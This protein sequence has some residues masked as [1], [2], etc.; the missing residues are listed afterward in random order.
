[1]EKK[2]SRK[3]L[4]C[5]ILFALPFVGVGLVATYLAGS[6]LFDW[7]RMKSWEEVPAQIVSVERESHRS[8]NSTSYRVTARYL[9][10]VDGVEHQGTRVALY[11]GAVGFEGY[12]KDVYAELSEH[13]RSKQPFRCF[14]NPVLVSES[15]LYRELHWGLL[16]FFGIFVVAFGGFGLGL[17]GAGIRG[18]AVARKEEELR[19]LAPDQPWLHKEEWRSRRIPS[20]MK[21]TVMLSGVMAIFWN[22]VSVPLAF[23]VPR[24][25]EKGNHAALIVLIF[26]IV[27][28]G[29]AIWAGQSFL[30]YRKFGR[31]VLSLRS[32]PGVVGGPLE[33]QVETGVTMPPETSFHLTLSSV[34]RVR[35]ASGRNRSTRE[36]VLW[37]RVQELDGEVHF[38]REG[39]VVPISFSIPFSCRPTDESDPDDR[40][41][42]RL[43]IDAA[44]PGIDYHAVFEV[45]VFRTEKSSENY[46][47]DDS[48]L[49]SLRQPLGLAT[50]LQ[51]AGIDTELMPAGKRFNFPMARHPGLAAG[52]SLF[53][54]IWTAVVVFLYRSDA[55]RLFPWL[56][57]LFDVLIVFVVLDMWFYRSSIEA[58]PG[59]LAFSAGLFGTGRKRKIPAAELHGV[60]PARG[61]QSGSRL[62]YRLE[63]S[64]EDGARYTVA[65]RLPDLDTAEE[66]A[67]EI[68]GIVKA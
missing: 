54:L 67:S 14:V 58:R 36:S 49:A 16:G 29:L 65:K 47:H 66:L 52:T 18:A 38:G 60:S 31:S 15:V 51:R 53:F 32:L 9:Y 5:L 48:R 22:V 11:E 39:T 46:V 19:A 20:S 56:F 59:E 13:F 7:A 41:V 57:G 44:L 63:V 27:G 21:S 2:A 64:T 28:L 24:E 37:Q 6:M 55:P 26:P 12:Q 23:L 17:I 4:G 35:S 10:R 61:T 62:F 30:R 1:L 42:W 40:V 25:L 43:S 33:G 3:G 8:S 68:Q 45:P 50:R 34:R